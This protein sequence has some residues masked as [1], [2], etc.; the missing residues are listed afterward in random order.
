LVDFNDGS[1]RT[2]PKTTAGRIRLVREV[3]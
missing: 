2:E 1:I 3:K